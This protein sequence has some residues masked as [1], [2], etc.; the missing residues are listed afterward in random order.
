MT[1]LPAR[2]RLRKDDNVERTFGGAVPK[3]LAGDSFETIT[4]Y[5]AASGFARD[6]EPE[7]GM[8]EVVGP[9]EHGEVLIRGSPGVGHD[10][11]ELRGTGQTLAA[12]E[13]RAGTLARLHPL[14]GTA[15][16]GPW[17]D[18]DSGPCDHRVSPYGLGNREF[19]CA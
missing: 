15:W 1:V 18:G 2:G 8:I 10:A 17:L 19:G 7:S 12:S 5:G 16:R 14:R 9:R 3:R 6:C 13:S 11:S 4:V